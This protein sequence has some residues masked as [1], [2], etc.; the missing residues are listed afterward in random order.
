MEILDALY[1]ERKALLEKLL[2][3]EQKIATAVSPWKKG[4]LVVGHTKYQGVYQVEAVQFK[5]KGKLPYVLLAYPVNYENVL[6]RATM[7]IAQPSELVSVHEVWQV[8]EGQLRME[9]NPLS[10]TLILKEDVIKTE[11]IIFPGTSE[12]RS[13]Y[14]ADIPVSEKIRRRITKVWWKEFCSKLE[15]AYMV[16]KGTHFHPPRM[17][18]VCQA[19]DL[20]IPEWWD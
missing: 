18:L 13:I 16:T 19:F 15:A 6:S 10:V 14:N 20:P 8:Q 12:E 5:E 17:P 4:D 11:V 2:E 7:Y 1:M 3:V 9:E